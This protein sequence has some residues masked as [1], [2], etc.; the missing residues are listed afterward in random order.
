MLASK[1]GSYLNIHEIPGAGITIAQTLPELQGYAM[2]VP[3]QVNFQE[4]TT[5]PHHNKRL[6]VI[7]Y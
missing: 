4:R 3:D 6:N 5:L 1:L 7:S 2:H